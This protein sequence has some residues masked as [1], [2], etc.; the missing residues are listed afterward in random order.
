[1]NSWLAIQM[2]WTWRT[3]ED[4]VDGPLTNIA[5]DVEQTILDLLGKSNS[6]IYAERKSTTQWFSPK[7][8]CT[9]QVKRMCSR[10][11]FAAVWRWRCEKESAFCAL[12]PSWSELPV[13]VIAEELWATDCQCSWSGKVYLSVTC[14][15]Q[16]PSEVTP[17]A[18]VPPLSFRPGSSRPGYVWWS[19]SP[20][21]SDSQFSTMTALQPY[22]KAEV[23][24]QLWAV[25]SVR[26]RKQEL[27][28]TGMGTQEKA[29][30]QERC[31]QCASK[32]HPFS[33]YLV[34]DFRKEDAKWCNNCSFTSNQRSKIY[35]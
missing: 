23:L 1:M 14:D 32:V 33:D 10:K 24:T 25:C 2:F 5:I 22:S 7:G 29:Y 27:Q 20:A 15:G 4:V 16:S 11:R 19:Q 28:N 3:L 6:V 26:N 9:W 31:L 8:L 21:F 30:Y 34:S 17:Q 18:K 13:F 12:G 35:P